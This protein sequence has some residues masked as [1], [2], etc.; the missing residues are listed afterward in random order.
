MCA[1]QHMWLLYVCRDAA[2]SAALQI[3]FSL[4][5]ADKQTFA[6][7]MSESFVYDCN[8]PELSR[9]ATIWMRC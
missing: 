6:V 2:E 9:M 4:S 5:C 3:T 7:L 8:F 1:E